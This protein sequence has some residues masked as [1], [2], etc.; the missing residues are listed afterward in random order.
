MEQSFHQCF[1]FI[2]TWDWFAKKYRF[3][4][5]SP[6][7]CFNNFVRFAINAKKE[8]VE[9]PSS[10]VLAETLKL[11]ANKCYGYQIMD[12]NR[13]TVKSYLIDKKTNGAIETKC[14]SKRVI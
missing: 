1:S 12:R 5:Y 2:W 6:M 7:K 3:D 11:L 8:G 9:N 4:Q 10:S 13:H 14:L